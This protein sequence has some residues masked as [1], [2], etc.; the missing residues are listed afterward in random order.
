MYLYLIHQNHHNYSG[1]TLSRM[2]LKLTGFPLTINGNGVE[3]ESFDDTGISTSQATINLSSEFK[4]KYFNGAIGNGPFIPGTNTQI[5]FA[6]TG[7]LNV[8][9]SMNLTNFL[10]N[11]IVILQ[12]KPYS[13]AFQSGVTHTINSLFICGFGG[14][15]PNTTVSAAVARF[16]SATPGTR[17]NINLLNPSQSVIAN[18]D[19]TDINFTGPAVFTLGSVGTIS[20]SVNVTNGAVGGSGTTA[21]GAWTFLN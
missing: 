19:V 12:Y 5:T 20:N 14:I 11:S 6:G 4:V 21:G 1:G 9:Q 15:T 7:A 17:A 18:T 8:T 2:R 3:F 16:R 13:I 10:F